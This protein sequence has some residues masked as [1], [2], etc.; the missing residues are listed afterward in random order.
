MQDEPNELLSKLSGS[1]VLE[2]AKGHNAAIVLFTPDFAK[3]LDDPRFTSS[4]VKLLSASE[5]VGNFH[6][7]S[8]IVD[9]IAPGLGSPD[10]HMPGVSVLRGHLDDLL[11]QLWQQTDHRQRAD[12]DSVAALNFTLGQPTVTLPLTRTTFYNHRTSTLLSSCYDVTQR[13]P[14]L[15]ER[16]EKHSQRINISVNQ[17]PRSIA[18]LGLWA[19]LSPVTRA[20]KIT[21]SFG[22]I[23]RGVEVEGKSTPA[24]T[25]LEHAINTLV[26]HRQ[27]TSPGPMGV[28][29]MITPEES[30]TS[31]WASEEAPDP[32]ET[33]NGNDMSRAA[34]EAAAGY[35]QQQF[36]GGGRIFQV[37][38]H[39]PR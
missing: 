39:T 35:I 11:P 8:A 7:L 9:S 26:K 2:N 30:R 23:L 19:P 21:E 5:N 28:W 15:K 24:S 13:E 34:V 33:L 36:H 17:P 32:T 22:N 16:A 14:E 31:S 4:L 12:E 27:P 20:R 37:G 1:A 10:P 29:A 38:K 6:L 25:E 3:Q 18:S